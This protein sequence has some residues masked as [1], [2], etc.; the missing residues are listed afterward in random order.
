MATPDPTATALIHELRNVLVPLDYK[1][2]RGTAT[3]EDCAQVVTR[4][5]AFADDLAR[6]LQGAP[7]G[8]SC[9]GCARVLHCPACGKRDGRPERQS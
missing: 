2:K 7:Q 8:Q 4:L 3:L 5:F 9:T 1:I 6:D